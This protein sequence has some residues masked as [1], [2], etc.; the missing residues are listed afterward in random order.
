MTE[1]RID[2]TTDRS[3]VTAAAVLAVLIECAGQPNGAL[4]ADLS[5]VILK[6]IGYDSLAQIEAAAR[7]A[8][9]YGVEIP[10][11]QVAELKTIGDM[12]TQA[13]A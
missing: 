7:L 5:S 2:L 9:Q 4:P 12:V 11:D 1:N 10:D 8:D 6:D 3:T 13:N